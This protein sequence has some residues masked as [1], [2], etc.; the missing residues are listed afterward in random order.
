MVNTLTEIALR[1]TNITEALWK[2]KTGHENVSLWREKK[3]ITEKEMQKGKNVLTRGDQ[4]TGMIIPLNGQKGNAI[5]VGV[6]QTGKKILKKGAPGEA[7]TGTIVKGPV[8]MIGEVMVTI[9]TMITSLLYVA[10][11]ITFKILYV[12]AL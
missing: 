7:H 1:G 8:K 12:I 2:G 4:L 9:S 3:A 6:L 11:Y 5:I 10:L